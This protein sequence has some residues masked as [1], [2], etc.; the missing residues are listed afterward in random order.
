MNNTK[1]GFYTIIGSAAFALASSATYAAGDVYFGADLGNSTYK[2]GGVSESATGFRLYAGMHINDNL[3][4]E[5]AWLNQGD[6]EQSYT[7]PWGSGTETVSLDGLQFSVLGKMPVQD[8]MDLFGRVG[9]YMWNASYEDIY[10]GSTWATADDD[11]SDIFF[12]LGMDYKISEN[13]AVRAEYDIIAVEAFTVDVDAN[14]LSVG[15]SY[16]P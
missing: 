13:M 14:R 11:G 15:I 8:N 16:R 3:S 7:D 5:G 12:G 4:V 10:N 9:M 2:A 1:K 6:S